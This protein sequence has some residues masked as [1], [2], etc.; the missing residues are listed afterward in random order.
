MDTK[1]ILFYCEDIE[2]EIRG[3]ENLRLWLNRAVEKE[4]LKSGFINII[5]CSDKYLIKLNK[6]Y[7]NHNYYTDIITFDFNNGNILSG[8]IYISI[9]RIR[10]NAKEFKC[11]V[12]S[13]LHR[14]IIHGVLHLCGYADS[15]EK[16]RLRMKEKED[17]YLSLL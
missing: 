17:Y 6:S 16:L 8:D 4:K 11:S 14:V 13:E 1:K 3:K 9:D 2:F 5:L 15:S 10:E 7:L 12:A